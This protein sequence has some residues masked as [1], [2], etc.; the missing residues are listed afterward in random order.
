MV[1]NLIKNIRNGMDIAKGEHRRNT[2]TWR[3]DFSKNWSLYLFILPVIA[4]YLIFCYYPM[5]GATI[6]F[7]DFRIAR[8]INGS[9]WVGLKHF[10]SFFKYPDVGR[11]FR[12]TLVM[13]I[14][15]L[16]VSRVTEIGFALMLHE[17]RFK[18]LKRVTQTIS[19]FPHFISSVVCCTIFS[20]FCL[21][22][23][24]FNNILS[25]FGWKPV[26]LLTLP[27]AFVPIMRIMG[28]WTGV[29]WGSIINLA[30]MS[31]IDPEIYEAAD[32]D[33]CTRIKRMFH[34]TVPAIRPTRVITLIMSI[35]GLLSVGHESIILMYNPSIYSTADVISTYVYR[36]GLVKFNYSYSSAIGLMN[37][38]F[39][40]ILLLIANKIA[41]TVTETSLL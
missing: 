11:L 29:G 20:N 19:I 1:S 18:K 30:A 7:K 31:G 41:K 10:I 27:N 23:G 12:N 6:A 3:K 17:L 8:G 37:S 28:V 22:D 14:S 15:G 32:L 34:I 16:I 21:T 39:N 9:E 35:G 13:S 5:Y 25:W 36:Q 40:I 2:S 33:G 24:L 26:N 38:V 4:F